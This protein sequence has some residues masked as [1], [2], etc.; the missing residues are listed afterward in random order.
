MERIKS[1]KLALVGLA[2][3][4]LFVWTLMNST[5]AYPTS[6]LE[7]TLTGVVLPAQDQ[8]SPGAYTLHYKGQTW[9][10]RVSEIS[11]PD[12]SSSSSVSGWSILKDMGRQRIRLMGNGD[13]L[14]SLNQAALECKQVNLR[15][16]LY[17]SFGALGFASVEETPEQDHNDKCG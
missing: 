1:S 6:S 16:T 8:D 14:E 17:V 15:G 5:D 4:A 12:T 2:F 7:V 13:F 9:N 11:V 10:F 3:S